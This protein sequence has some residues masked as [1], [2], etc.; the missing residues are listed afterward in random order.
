MSGRPVL[1]ASANEG[2]LFPAP[3]SPVTTTRR[4]MAD[5]APRMAVRIAHVPARWDAFLL[6]CTPWLD[7]AGTLVIGI[8]TAKH[9]VAGT[10]V[11]RGGVPGSDRGYRSN[12][13]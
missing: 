3:A 9:V 4:P 13:E 10:D 2:V 1:A 7:V 11:P 5:G 12:V 8:N 6:R